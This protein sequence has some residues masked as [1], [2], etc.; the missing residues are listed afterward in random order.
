[1]KSIHVRKFGPIGRVLISIAIFLILLPSGAMAQKEFDRIVV[2]GTSL[3]DPGNAFA[4]L[5]DP[6]NPFRLTQPLNVPPY[7]KLDEYLV[8]DRPYAKGGHHFTNGA[9]WIEQFAQ[10]QGFAGDV[11]PAF[12]GNSTKATN[13]AIGGTRA[14]VE[15]GNPTPTFAYQMDTFVG[16]FSGTPLPNTL[17]VIEMGSNDVRDALAIA[18]TALRSGV[19]KDK[20]ITK[21]SVRLQAALSEINSYILYLEGTNGANKFLI[22][23]VPDIGLVPAVKAFGQ[24]VSDLATLL[25]EQFNKAL[26]SLPALSVSGVDVIKLD[27]FAKL[28]SFVT[29]P[30]DFGFTNV[31]TPC[32]NPDQPPF[33]CQKPD[34]Y[35]FWDGIHPT[36][37][38]HAII[39]QDAVQAIAGLKAKP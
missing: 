16:R 12:Q 19:D 35:L 38:A 34:T 36:K 6:A 11:R 5:N 24:G 29:T 21:A 22:L 14:Y 9:T 8:P 32:V 39:A 26:Y 31:D 3:S 37:A 2:F 15:P 20:A 25:T 17:Y 23:N 1:M 28:R 10:G 7:D 33:I 18:L 13:Y 4:L 27:L 30:G